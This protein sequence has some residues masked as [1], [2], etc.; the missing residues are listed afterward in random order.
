MDELAACLPRKWW[1]VE[2]LVQVLNLCQCR[3]AGDSDAQ[4]QS[5]VIG[6]AIGPANTE[7]I[8]SDPDRRKLDS[9]S[10]ACPGADETWLFRTDATG[11]VPSTRSCGL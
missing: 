2:F 10:L 6:P 11:G 7:I 8:S 3:P 1:L 5:P 4:F 9:E